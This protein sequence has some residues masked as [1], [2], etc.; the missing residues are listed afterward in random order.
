MDPQAQ[1]LAMSMQQLVRQMAPLTSAMSD[2]QRAMST[3]VGATSKFS[4]DMKILNKLSENEQKAYIETV[5]NLRSMNKE[6][7]SL[8]AQLEDNTLSEKDRGVVLNQLTA[9]E[10]QRKETTGQLATYAKKAGIELSGFEAKTSI[11]AKAI[12]LLGNAAF[13][14]TK[15]I[16]RSIEANSGTIV[17][18]GTNFVAAAVKQQI[19]AIKH[20]VPVAQFQEISASNRALIDSLG[21]TDQMLTRVGGSMNKL[22]YMTSNMTESMRVAAGMATNLAYAG[23]EPTT[24]AMGVYFNNLNLLSRMTGLTAQQSQQQIASMMQNESMQLLLVRA[25][26]NE[27]EAIVESRMA[28]LNHAIALTGSTEAA[29]KM[30]ATVNKMV[31]QDP[32]ERIKQAAKLQALAGA[33]GV[34]VNK[35]AIA[36]LIS[37][38][39]DASQSMAIQGMMTQLQGAANTRMGGGLAGQLVTSTMIGKLGLGNVLNGTTFTTPGM[40]VMGRGAANL[41]QQATALGTATGKATT[42][43]EKLAQHF[44]QLDKTLSVFGTSVSEV[45]HGDNIANI[46]AGVGTLVGGKA[47]MK[48]GGWAAKKA[49]GLLGRGGAAAAEGEAAGVAAEGMG[50]ASRLKGGLVGAVVGG[51]LDLAGYELKK[52]HHK[53]LGGLASAGGDAATGA[54]MGMMLGPIGAAIGGALGGA[55]GLYE[56][57]KDIFGGKSS[58]P[59]P[60]ERTPMTTAEKKKPDPHVVAI[61]KAVE[62]QT[63]RA[64]ESAN[65]LTEIAK[66]TKQQVDLSEKSLAMQLT[67]NKDQTTSQIKQ[68]LIGSQEFSP[69]YNYVH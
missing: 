3:S 38:H 21:G 43:T 25:R 19:D 69:V 20:G 29:Q 6:I 41:N 51:G 67:A 65:S 5:N 2:L 36:G 68:S 46:A 4:M 55:Y 30:V 52:H 61:S 60:P 12:A 58:A 64:D 16:N 7:K 9:L 22:W 44:L 56:N 63:K 49:G 66:L 10:T 45:L 27:R 48:T 47:L 53:T 42:A 24:H 14:F 40:S 34:G 33:M 39:P 11:A 28:L 35:G 50:L 26:S 37:G 15:S 13:V 32:L 23:V 62:Q 1:Q 54:A 17:G 59:K 31:T 57:R 18:Y 8:M